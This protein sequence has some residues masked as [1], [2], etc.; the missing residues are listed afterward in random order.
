MNELYYRTMMMRHT[1]AR[2]GPFPAYPHPALPFLILATILQIC[3]A[4]YLSTLIF[5]GARLAAAFRRR[6]GLARAGSGLVG[7]LFL[8]FA[9]RMAFE[10]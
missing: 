5:G 2:T 4:L 1:G 7:M 6:Q 8:W 10:A 9:G 3:S